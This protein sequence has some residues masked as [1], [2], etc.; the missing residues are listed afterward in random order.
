MFSSHPTSFLCSCPFSWTF[1]IFPSS[2]CFINLI[3]LSASSLRTFQDHVVIARVIIARLPTIK[4]DHWS[5]RLGFFSLVRPAPHYALICILCF[6][7]YDHT[8]FI[9]F[10]LVHLVVPKLCFVIDTMSC[11]SVFRS[12]DN[13]T[14]RWQVVLARRRAACSP[15][16]CE[17]NNCLKQ[18]QCFV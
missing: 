10:C 12:F 16:Y 15:K 3:N 8:A 4:P 14:W 1:I 17:S 5:S 13:Q 2:S 11:I 18:Q 9:Y 7:W 6:N